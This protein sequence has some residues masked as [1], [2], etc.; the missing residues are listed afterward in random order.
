[1]E[2]E[3]DTGRKRPEPP[4]RGENRGGCRHRARILLA[5]DDREMRSMLASV[6]RSDGYHIIEFSDGLVLLDF[7]GTVMLNPGP[8]SRV[9][10]IIS[11]IRMPGW[12]GLDIL[13]GMRRAGWS[14]PFILITAFGGRDVQEI[15]GKLGAATVLNK[16]FDIDDLRA[17]LLGV[18][19]QSST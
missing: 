7:I 2:H 12:T 13:A 19:R 18:T 3:K 6:L 10:V 16:P 14:V 8:M 1:M 4:P 17:E 5:E 9:D 15:A 11:D